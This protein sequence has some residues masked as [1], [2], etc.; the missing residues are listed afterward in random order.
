MSITVASPRGGAD[1]VTIETLSPASIE[2]LART[3][4]SE[5]DRWANFEPQRRSE[6]LLAF[7]AAMEA[8][9]GVLT[10]ALAADTGRSLLAGVE[11]AGAMNRLSYWAQR[12][13]ALLDR[14]STGVSETAPSVRYEHQWL[15]YPLVGVVSPWN[16]PLLLTLTDAIP[17]LA[18]GCAV[19]A[20]PSEIT[21][22]FIEPLM[23][24]VAAVPDLASVFMVIP[25][26]GDVG[27]AVLDQVDAVCFTGSVETGRKVGRAAGE[28]L[29]PAFLELGGKDPMIILPGTDLELATRAALRSAVI[30][31]GQACQSIE[32]FYVHEDLFDAFVERLVASAR[33]VT[34]NMEDI[35][36]GQL[37]PFID[38]RQADKVEA[39]IKD[40]VAAGATLHCGGIQRQ[41]GGAWCLPAVLTDVHHGMALYQEETFGPVLPVMPFESIGQAVGLANDTHFGLS[42]AVIG[43]D[44]AQAMDVA[45][46]IDAGAVS[47]N[48]GG[49]TTL[50]SDVEKESFGASGVGRSRMGASGLHRFLRTKAILIQQDPPASIDQFQEV[51][52]P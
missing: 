25:G 17:A 2:L 38:R 21:P 6:V 31:T 8:R 12:A 26:A 13:P 19:L 42:A 28:R 1:S 44:E 4:R 48:D 49:L 50:V 24:C 27:A 47:V 33:A 7:R 20:K 9:Q 16:F 23:D 35:S 11:V 52:L 5:Q 29:I 30:S 14:D 10:R 39:Q 34:T 22:R 51:P 18:A 43:P 40:A 46:R 37:G 41:D 32:R 45:R 3:L 36:R 15:P